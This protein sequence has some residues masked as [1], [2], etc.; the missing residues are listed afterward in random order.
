MRFSTTRSRDFMYSIFVS[1][2]IFGIT[3]NL[4]AEEVNYEGINKCGAM[5][6]KVSFTYD[7]AKSTIKDFTASHSC[8]RGIEGQG[9]ISS[10]ISIPISV[11]DNKFGISSFVEGTI[12]SNGKA[13]G[14]LMEAQGRSSQCPDGKMHANCVEW[15]AIPVK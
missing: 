2:F 12:S 4:Y 6:V 10:N 1:I 3:S 11:K 5:Q 15:K 8:V 13:S 9:V 7:K 14:K